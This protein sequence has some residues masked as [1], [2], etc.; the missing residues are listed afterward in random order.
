MEGCTVRNRARS[1]PDVGPLGG[2]EYRLTHGLSLFALLRCTPRFSPHD[3][4]GISTGLDGALESPLQ[5]L[6]IGLSSQEEASGLVGISA[7]GDGVTAVGMLQSRLTHIGGRGQSGRGDRSG[8][9]G[10]AFLRPPSRGA[11]HSFTSLPCLPSH[12]LDTG[13]KPDPMDSSTFRIQDDVLARTTTDEEG[14]LQIL[15][16]ACPFSSSAPT[17]VRV[18][19]AALLNTAETLLKDPKLNGE[20][21][22]GIVKVENLSGLHLLVSAFFPLAR[23]DKHLD[24]PLLLEL[25]KDSRGTQHK[26]ILLKLIGDYGLGYCCGNVKA[27]TPGNKLRLI[28]S[29]IPTPT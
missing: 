14:E 26:K 29:Q 24:I 2:E 3:Q 16:R 21:T 19:T 25:A 7:R 28:I 27:H 10:S 4:P 20:G 11:L 18:T 9:A 12:I 17:A 5:F 23:E 13:G 6:I 8:I 22:P 1:F 15:C